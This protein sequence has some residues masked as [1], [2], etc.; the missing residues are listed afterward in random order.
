MAKSHLKRVSAPK[1]WDITRK[2]SKFIVRPKGYIESSMPLAVILKESLKLAGTRA[3]AKKIVNNGSVSVDGKAAK[4]D[5]LPAG[6]MSV[7]SVGGKDYR[8]LI[9]ARGKLFL[10]TLNSK[11][12]SLKLCKIVSKTTLKGNKLQLG[13]HDGRT[14]LSEKKDF[15]LNDTIAFKLPDFKIIDS[16]KLAKNAKAYLTGGSNVGRTG[17]IES[18]SDDFVILKIGSSSVKA[19]KE[20]VFVIGNES[21]IISV[22]D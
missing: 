10:K 17:T 11:E 7:I 3:E 9:N 8:M 19:S 22:S 6:M 15:R 21:E 4:S 1:T 2:S 5:R 18:V 12:S 14:M 16:L 20:N 13:F